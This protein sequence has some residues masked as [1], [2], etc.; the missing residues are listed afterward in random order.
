VTADTR[1][2]RLLLGQN[3]SM[4]N[5]VFIHLSADYPTPAAFDTLGTRV[6]EYERTHNPSD[7]PGTYLQAIEACRGAQ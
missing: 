2:A 4:C 1:P 7:I 5:C 3:A 6:S